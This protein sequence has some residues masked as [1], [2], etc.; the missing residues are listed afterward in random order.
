MSFKPLKNF[1]HLN[2]VSIHIKLNSVS[3]DM[4]K[5]LNFRNLNF[6]TIKFVLSEDLYCHLRLTYSSNT[7]YAKKISNFEYNVKKIQKCVGFFSFWYKI[8]LFFKSQFFCIK[9]LKSNQLICFYGSCMSHCHDSS[10]KIDLKWP[11]LV[12]I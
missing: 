7:F 2:S 9:S 10:K 8:P 3:F 4:T 11:E 5:K 12:R 1:Q 6:H